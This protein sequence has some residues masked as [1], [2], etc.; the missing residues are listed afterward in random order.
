MRT[1]N[2]EMPT[3]DLEHLRAAALT[4]RRPVTPPR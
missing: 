3:L 1:L 2:L 4:P